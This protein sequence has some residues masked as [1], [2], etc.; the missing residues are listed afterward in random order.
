VVLRPGLGRKQSG[1]YYT[2]RAFVEYL[3]RRAVDPLAE[4][5][6]PDQILKLAVCDPAMGSGH[7]LVGACRRLSEHLLGAFKARYAEEQERA[8]RG[9]REAYPHELLID[10]GIHAEVARHWGDEP[11]ELTACR[12]LVAA[13][14]IYGVDLNPLSVELARVSLWLATAASDHP[15]T[16]L[17][18]RLVPGNSLLGIRVDD[19]LRAFTGKRVTKQLTGDPSG[20]GLLELYFGRN[21]LNL[22]IERAFSFLEQIERLET[23]QPGDFEDQQVAYFAMR[24]ELQDFLDAHNLRIGRAF[25]NANDPA[26]DR[27]LANEWMRE[28]EQL[29]HVT[30][31]TRNK[32]ATAIAKG[33]ELC[34]FCWEL[35]FPELF[36]SSDRRE[37]PGFDA[38]V[39]NPP[40]DTI[41]PKT[42]EFFAQFDP[43][44]RDFQGQSLNRHLIQLAPPGSE[45]AQAWHRFNESQRALATLLIKGGSYEHQVVE[46]SGVKTCGDPDLFKL[47]VE[48]FH[49]LVRQGGRVGILMP[50]GLYALEGATGI[51]LMLFTSSRVE[52]M[53]SFENA[54]ER[55]FPGVDS[56]TKF[57]VLTFEKQRAEDQSFPAAF[58]LRD[59]NFLSLPDAARDARSVRFTSAFIRL[60]NPLYRSL[61]E[62][63]DTKEQGFVERI[64]RSVPP[65][66]EKRD[67]PG[68]WNVRIH[69]ELHS[70]D[71]AWRFRSRPWLMERGCRLE[72]SIFVAPSDDWYRERADQF[73][74]GTRY[75]VP[76]GSKFRIASEKP[77]E[78]GSKRGR[79]GMTVQA[80]S[81]FVFS[82]RADDLP[83]VRPKSAVRPTL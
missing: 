8:S 45:R 18:H 34:A 28:I 17:D 59:E 49:Q 48:R 39:G 10:A 4:G 15:L 70:G 44:I 12:Q 25:L 30:A 5:K 66:A 75:I 2:N 61:I 52:A 20:Q 58:M 40:W 33:K 13:H 51:R 29:H 82:D 46:V 35:T 16:F 62:L 71:D 37:R 83:V 80:I 74:P 36:F 3:V 55:F 65:L 54:F 21:E 57:V 11:A 32:A 14:C 76:D 6:T 9:G 43:A 56:R 77:D 67:G 53:Y 19:L 27:L 7:F 38:M 22:R 69:R 31:D 64:Y 78:D 1:S 42:K 79:R 63:R 26:A 68:A 23:E 73:F 50:A 72:G 24:Q 47:F 41:R 81:G 60:T